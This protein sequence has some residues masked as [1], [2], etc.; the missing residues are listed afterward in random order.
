MHCTKSTRRMKFQTLPGWNASFLLP[1]SGDATSWEFHNTLHT[2]EL[3]IPIFPQVFSSRCS[4]CS[5]EYKIKKTNKTI[6]G[7][8]NQILT[9]MPGFDCIQN[10]FNH[11]TWHIKRLVW[12]KQCAHGSLMQLNYA[13]FIN[14]SVHRVIYV[15]KWWKLQFFVNS[16]NPARD[17]PKVYPASWTTRHVWMVKNS[18]E[19]IET[20]ELM[21]SYLW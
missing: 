10:I 19:W 13:H 5:G 11:H 14:W 20:K 18:F 16:F 17:L 8:C 7:K 1:T 12:W 21:Q 15:H 9:P 2:C 6:T 3:F 4:R